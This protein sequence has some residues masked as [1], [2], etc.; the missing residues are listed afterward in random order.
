MNKIVSIIVPVYKVEKYIAQ[1]MQSLLDQEYP[2]FEAIIVNDGSLDCSMG[3][4][5]ALVGDDPRFIFL[6]KD[7]GGLSSA[8]NFGLD[9]A[10]GQYIAFL[11]SDDYWEH[12]CLAKVITA[13]ETDKKAEIIIFGFNIVDDQGILLERK[14]SDIE[15][16]YV[17]NDILLSENTISYNVSDKVYIKEVWGDLRFQEGIIYEDKQLMPIV[18]YQRK[19]HLLQEYLYCYVQR[20]GSITHTYN[21]EKSIYSTVLIYKKYKVFLELHNIYYQYQSYYQ[22]AYIKYCFYQHLYQILA[23]SDHYDIDCRYLLKNID[24]QIVTLAK[25][26]QYYGLFSKEFQIAALFKLSPKLFKQ[27]LNVKLGLKYLI[28]GGK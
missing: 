22:K 6:D 25:V 2:Y 13:F 18:L 14:I 23:Y 10:S 19:L 16:Y 7:N 20:D 9:R 4:A 11:D 15:D 27:V 21:K 5:K 3:I 26:R 1:C 8:R 24:G 28:K 12:D 17:C